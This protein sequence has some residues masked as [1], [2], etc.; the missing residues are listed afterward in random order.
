[1]LAPAALVVLMTPF[2]FTSHL[3][4]MGMF[5][6][7]LYVDA[8]LGMA[9]GYG[10]FLSGR[11]PARSGFRLAAFS[12][13]MGVLCL[14]KD[15]G[16][17]FAS[18]ALVIALILDRRNWKKFL[19]PGAVLAA[20]VLSWKLLLRLYDIHALVPL[21]VHALSGEAIKNV[22]WAMVSYNVMAYELP[23][24]M[25]LSFGIVFPVL[26]VVYVFA[27]RLPKEQSRGAT[28]G[29]ALGMV[30]STAAFVY[31]Y[32]LIY[33]ET[34]ESFVRYME[35]PLLALFT[36]ILLTAVPALPGSK[37]MDWADGR[38][39]KLAVTVFAGCVLV[40]CALT[41]V[42][43]YIFPLYTEIP[44]ADRDAATIRAAVEQDM[45]P[46]ETGWVYLVMAGDGWE[47]SYY[48]H[49]IFFDLISPD[50]N[51]RN[52]FAQTQVVIPGV[53]NPGQKWAEELKDGCDYVYLLTVE[54][55]FVPVF[56]EFSEDAPK[57][58]GLYRVI[59]TESGH[60]VALKLVH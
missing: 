8:L 13:T 7:T 37:L 17:L 5:G 57:E 22:M 14:L 18:F 52:G 49:R 15:T 33:G 50:I 58:H 2:A 20:A 27:A 55:A 42:W 54:D 44:D 31:G 59:P 46:G 6:M 45:E 16:L 21:T 34:L 48:H 9:A 53:E 25:L 26:M 12:L 56:G 35:T 32:A 4:D 51:I 1:M 47:N 43:R 11:Y 28:I 60:G 3:W 41:V 30:L 24:G 29:V 38:S 40:G 19:L 10:L 39:Q 23:V 36:C